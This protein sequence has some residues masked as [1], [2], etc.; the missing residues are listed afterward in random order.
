MFLSIFIHF[1]YLFQTITQSFYIALSHIN[2]RTR[3]NYKGAAG[4]RQRLKIIFSSGGPARKNLK[5]NSKKSHSAENCRTVPNMS[6][7]ISLYIEMNYR[8]LS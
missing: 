7:S 6:D 1:N 8:M 4:E 5:K 3:I 2:I